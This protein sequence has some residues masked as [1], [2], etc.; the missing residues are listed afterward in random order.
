MEVI[1]FAFFAIAVVLLGAFMGAIVEA[2]VDGPSSTAERR[3]TPDPY[4]PPRCFECLD[5]GKTWSTS[6]A[7]YG[8]S[9]LN[10]VQVPCP[11][12]CSGI[13]QRLPD[14]YG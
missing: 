6:S 13:R 11:R 9:F 14:P 3:S 10:L 4:E 7:V 1:L 8:T 2:I 12:G 5:S